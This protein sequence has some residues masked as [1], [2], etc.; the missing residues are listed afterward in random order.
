MRKC[1]K[2]PLEKMFEQSLK[3]GIVHISVSECAHESARVSGLGKT[4]LVI[5]VLKRLANEN[6][7]FKDM[8][9]VAVDKSP[10]VL[11]RCVTGRL[12]GR[13]RRAVALLFDDLE[14][15]VGKLDIAQLVSSFR[16]IS[17]NV[18][19]V[20]TCRKE[21]F[22]KIENEQDVTRLFSQK[23]GD[24]ISIPIYSSSEGHKMAMGVVKEF[25]EKDFRG[26]ADSIVLQTM[27]SI[28]RST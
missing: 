26:T 13:K 20:A 17:K 6:S 11:T 14:Q 22:S 23:D 3:Q 2:S 28:D 1:K 15:Y 12:L 7:D 5:E 4:R 24:Y 10:D 16:K 8:L 25:A 9:V 18:A 19:V 21:E 27:R